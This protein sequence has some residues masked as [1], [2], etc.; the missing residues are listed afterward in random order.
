MLKARPSIQAMDEIV[1][2]RA[3]VE[4]PEPEVKAEAPKAPKEEPK[5]EAVV[6]AP[7][8][9][10]AEAPKVVRVKVDGDEFDAPADEVEAA[11]GVKSFQIL[12][13]AENRF[14]K[15]NKL[16][17]ES[18]KSQS[19]ILQ[20]VQ[21]L[22]QQQPKQE[23]KPVQSDS[24][25]IA[26]KLQ[27]IRFGSDEEGA[28]ALQEVLSRFQQ[29]QVDPNELVSAAT[30]RFNNQQAVE[31]FKKEFG[32][33]MA[34]PHLS[35]LA[36]VLDTERRQQLPVGQAVDWNDFYRKI[37][38]ELR[39]LTGKQSQPAT[40]TKT[41]GNTSQQSVKEERKAS[42]STIPTAA[43]RAALPEPEK[44]LTPEEERKA[45]LASQKKARGQG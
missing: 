12:K 30:N 11:G 40:T 27:T 23:A 17:E 35:K 13:A 33:V 9:A 32:D 22:L 19:Q 7:A 2:K 10:V 45:W 14:A 42:I 24:Q 15:A 20:L 1:K 25:F 43:A 26:S 31:N 41:D 34:N 6:E 38:N 5:S 39:P 37:G 16:V 3:P 44:E 18:G 21:A 29:K 8:E 28:S 36:A 4:E